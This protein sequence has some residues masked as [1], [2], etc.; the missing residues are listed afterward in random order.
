MRGFIRD[1]I[2]FESKNPLH[3]F[4]GVYCWASFLIGLIRVYFSS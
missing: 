3:I 2:L 4:L 1:C